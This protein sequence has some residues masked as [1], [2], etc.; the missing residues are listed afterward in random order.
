MSFDR[1]RAAAIGLEVVFVLGLAGIWLAGWFATTGSLNN[2]GPGQRAYLLGV[3]E[4]SPRIWIALALGGVAVAAVAARHNAPTAAFVVAAIAVA[5]FELFFPLYASSQFS[6]KLILAVTAFWALWKTQRFFPMASAAFAVAIVVPLRNWPVQQQ[7][8]DSNAS[9]F[10][11]GAFLG[12][13]ATSLALMTVVVAGA[14]LIRRYETQRL[15][16]A[17][18]NDELERQRSAT[19]RAAVL[20]ERVRIARELHDVVAHH[21][22]TMTVHAGAAR[23]VISQNPDAAADALQQIEG[24][25]RGAITELQRL[26]GF[27]RNDDG[28]KGDDRSP[29]P[30]LRH[31]DRLVEH[32]SGLTIDV[33]VVGDVHRIPPSVDVSAYRIVQEALTNAVKHS[34]A[35]RAQ[36]LIDAG[37]ER[38]EVTVSNAGPARPGSLANGVDPG[39]HGLLGMRERAALHS[40]TVSAGPDG[41]G[42]WSVAACLPY[43]GSLP[44]ERSVR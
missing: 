6:S 4:T 42:G 26:L 31:I 43:A 21:V 18:R 38:V 10:P 24:A 19:A 37:V 28:A 34:T 41:F 39:G 25:G 7:L 35:A 29:I 27:L 3:W 36:V 11:L 14:W 40:G 33:Q 44:Q 17:A 1:Q 12:L 8:A 32:S 15:E 13:L 9:A 23:Q 22:S 16:L 20:D 2:V 30:S 5:V